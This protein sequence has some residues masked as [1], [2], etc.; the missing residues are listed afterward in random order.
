MN[1][2]APTTEIDAR[3]WQFAVPMS[4]PTNV[5][6]AYANVVRVPLQVVVTPQG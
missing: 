6:E 3:Q 5:G 1:A 2:P 4:A